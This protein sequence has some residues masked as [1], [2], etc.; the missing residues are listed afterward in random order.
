MIRVEG[1][2]L[3]YGT[4]TVLDRLDLRVARG[5]SVAL[6]GAS[7]SG[8]TTL[9]RAIVGLAEPM[10][11]RVSLNGQDVGSVPPHARG[12]GFVFQS[13]NLWPHLTV[14]DNITF[15][16]GHLPRVERRA[17]LNALLAA[18]GLEALE[19]RYPPELSGGEARRV[20]LARALAP[21]RPI[22]LL[23]EPTVNLNPELAAA[24]L[25]LIAAERRARG[26]TLVLVTH[27]REEAVKLA[28][29][30]VWLRNGRLD[31]LSGGPPC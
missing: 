24:M 7:G 12:A 27:Q 5:E 1:L 3:S 15:G 18:I 21:R 16:I 23:D 17:R 11:G 31:D 29:R 22:L 30:L 9:L 26:T 6:L 19:H 2:T 28:D 4:A 14:G 13:A 20:A 8:K 25:D 10:A